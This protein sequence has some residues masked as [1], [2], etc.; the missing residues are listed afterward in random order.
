MMRCLFLLCL[1]WPCS[2]ATAQ[3]K[4]SVN[5]ASLERQ[6]ELKPDDPNI[7]FNLGLLA[8]QAHQ[9]NKAQSALGKAARLNPNDS[10]TFEL[11]GKVLQ[12]KGLWAE[13]ALAYGRCLELDGSRVEA[14]VNLAV[15]LSHL[16][17]LDE[18]R[19]SFDKAA[20]QSP[21]DPQIHANLGLLW[22]RLKNPDK[23]L[24]SFERARSL[25]GSDAVV[26][27]NLCQLY[28][29]KERYLEAEAA[30]KSSSVH[31]SEKPANAEYNLGYALVKLGRSKD[32]AVHFNKALG[33]DPAL[34]SAHYNLGLI[35]YEQGSLELAAKDFR[36]ALN[37][38]GGTYPEARYNLAV[39]LGD[40]G[41]WQQAAGEYRSV[42][43]RNPKDEDARANLDFVINRGTQ[44]FLD[45]G[46]AAFLEGNAPAAAKAWKAALA[47]DGDNATAKGFLA[48]AEEK[49]KEG[50]LK[51]SPVL[52]L[53]KSKQESEDQKILAQGMA[54]LDKGNAAESVRIL[55]Y[56][57]KGHPGHAAARQALYKSR[58]QLLR[59]VSNELDKAELAR[60]AGDPVAAKAFVA[61]ALELDA[62]NARAIGL[63]LELTGTAL[64]L[65][66]SAQDLQALYFQGVKQ[67]LKGDLTEAKS[68][69]KS[70]LASD[71][72]HLEARRN[73]QRVDAELVALAKFKK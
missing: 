3:D 47:L 65:D 25:D 11:Y 22:M 19:Q 40:R 7:Q 4:A 26:L 9:L 69:W 30:C 70:L 10:E 58:S 21:K 24:G 18:A 20:A 43:A 48:K 35:H 38:R 39:V 57:V 32:A 36:A 15:A 17:R 54:L 29:Q 37:A 72:G 52:E 55:S 71:P 5:M 53:A 31:P 63:N 61:K 27:A 8:Y 68:T 13:S 41:Q 45:Q 73:L 16:G 28:N 46:T 42:L 34:A 66:L 56:F 33:M 67:Y 49:I 62:D 64:K 60:D 12:D 6:A 50:G 51:V 14:R 2:A 1:I 44:D 59:Q 23:A